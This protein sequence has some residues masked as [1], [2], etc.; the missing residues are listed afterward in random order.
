MDTQASGVL[1]MSARRDVTSFCVRAADTIRDAVSRIDAMRLGI[2]LVVDADGRLVGTVTDGD[3]RRAVL[4]DVS[5]DRPVQM[6]LD[7]KAD[8]P[9]PRPITALA[10]A[11]PAAL[12]ALLQQ[13]GVTHLPLVDAEG[14]PVDLVTTD[15]FLPAQGGAGLQ[16]VIMAGGPG[17]RLRPLTED[18]PKPMLPIG[19]R[20]LMEIIIEQ[21][22][23]AGIRRVNV[24]THHRPEKITGHFGDGSNFGVEINYVEEDQP[25]G[26]A[27]ALGLIASPTETLLVINGDIL[28]QVGIR[29]MVTYH[30]EHRADLTVAVRPYAVQVPYG[31]VESEGPRVTRLTEKPELRFFVNAGIYLVEPVVHGYIPGGDR[32]DMTDLIVRLIGAGRTVISFPLHE[33]WLDIGQHEDY[34]RA[35]QDVLGLKRRP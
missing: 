12:L 10:D 31:V 29:A 25:L 5:L 20:P 18:V 30:R 9:F 33:Y 35:Q 23:E 8:S 26:T 2:A 6:L 14:R 13:Y 17:S 22:R 11:P 1:R 7:S 32:F 21:L 16:A 19:G 15:D 34:E 24:T 4:A 28:T 3:V 27:G